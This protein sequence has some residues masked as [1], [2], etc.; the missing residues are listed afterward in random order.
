MLKQSGEMAQHAGNTYESA[1][2]AAAADPVEKRVGKRQRPQR[3]GTAP[4][5]IFGRNEKGIVLNVVGSRNCE[6]R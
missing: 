2:A 4:S 1:E 6:F 3:P 5:K